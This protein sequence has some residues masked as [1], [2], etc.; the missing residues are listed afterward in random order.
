MW[1]VSSYVWLTIL[2]ILSIAIL[3][4]AQHLLTSDLS[5]SVPYSVAIPPQLAKD[6]RWDETELREAAERRAPEVYHINCDKDRS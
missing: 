1:E 5:P 3:A 2:I 4:I 6:Y